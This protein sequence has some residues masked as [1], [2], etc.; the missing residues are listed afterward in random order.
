[1]SVTMTIR[2]ALNYQGPSVA[3]QLRFDALPD[4]VRDLVLRIYGEAPA[5]GDG[6]W[7]SRDAIEAAYKAGFEAGQDA[8]ELERL[9]LSKR[10]VQEWIKS[11]TKGREQ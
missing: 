6:T 1:M 2:P 11:Y 10:E 8:V 5:S 9:S 4:D 7:F 3:D